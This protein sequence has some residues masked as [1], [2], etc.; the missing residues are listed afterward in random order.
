MRHRIYEQERSGRQVIGQK[1]FF[2]RLRDRHRLALPIVVAYLDGGTVGE[3]AGSVGHI[4]Q[5]IGEAEAF[6]ANGGDP[7]GQQ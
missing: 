5:G 4:H 1:C 3:N 2:E 6:R 7:H